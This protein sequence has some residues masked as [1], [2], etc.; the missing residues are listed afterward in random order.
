MESQPQ[1][2]EFQNNPEKLSPMNQ[3][4]GAK[5]LL[6]QIHSLE[7]NQCG[8]RSAGFTTSQ[9]ILRILNFDIYIHSALTRSNMLQI[10][11]GLS[12]IPCEYPGE[13]SV[14]LY[15]PSGLIS[16]CCVLYM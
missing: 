14:L 7:E 15:H 4:S 8:S 12:Q 1:N 3:Y 6:I 5:S 16:L 10:H 2:P 9:L 13:D 11:T